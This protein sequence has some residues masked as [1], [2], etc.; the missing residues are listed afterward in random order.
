MGGHL[1][2]PGST[3]TRACRYFRGATFTGASRAD[4]SEAHFKVEFTYRWL[5]P[6]PGSEA[7]CSRLAQ[8]GPRSRGALARGAGLRDSESARAGDSDSE[9]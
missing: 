2:L 4:L 5:H 1:N 9:Q 7:P 6:Q 8:L 3:G